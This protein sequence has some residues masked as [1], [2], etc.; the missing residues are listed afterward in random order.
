[1]LSDILSDTSAQIFQLAF[2]DRREVY[3]D[4]QTDIDLLL[5]EMDRLREKLDSIP[6]YQD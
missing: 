3:K 5:Q 2:V 4:Y 6:P 1:M